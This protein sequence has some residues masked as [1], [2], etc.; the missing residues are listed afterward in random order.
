VLINELSGGNMDNFEP[1]VEKMRE[2]EVSSFFDSS[3][4]ASNSFQAGEVIVG[5]HYATAAWSLVDSGL[6]IGY[7]VP[8]EGA[9]TGDIRVHIVKD[10]PNLE[11]AQRFVDHAVS[12]DVATCM[13][14]T[15][16]VGPATAGVEVSPEAAERMPWGSGGS[17]DDLSLPDWTEINANRD[18]IVEI[19]NQQVIGN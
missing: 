17:I 7:S 10:T 12:P 15:L 11:A 14:E 8:E 6:P 1:G 13:A 9:P 5:A 4:S 3:G 2:L 19:F 16:Y 18:R